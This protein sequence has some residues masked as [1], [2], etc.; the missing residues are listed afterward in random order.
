MKPMAQ[1]ILIVDDDRE[2]VQL[3]REAL[4]QVGYRVLVAHDGEGTLHILRRESPDLLLIDL[5]PSAGGGGAGTRTV[6]GQMSLVAM[7]VIRLDAG[8]NGEQLSEWEPDTSEPLAE[9]LNPGE[10]VAWL[11]A[12]LDHARG[13][14]APSQ[15][16]QAGNLVI[17]LDR[18]QAQVGDQPLHLT[19]TELGLLQALAERPGHTLSRREMMEKGLGYRYEGVGR[20]VDSH[21]KNLRRKLAR[22][23]APAGMVETVFGVGYRLAEGRRPDGGTNP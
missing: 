5:A 8:R 21:V 11:R 3:L 17:D 20:T 19:A 22:A 10:I 15:V 23:G 7:P 18:R 1:Q 13:G 12:A 4:E 2:L 16:I 6:G 14:S 9:P